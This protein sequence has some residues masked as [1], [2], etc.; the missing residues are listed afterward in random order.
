MGLFSLLLAYLTYPKG[1]TGQYII[2]IAYFI[3]IFPSAIAVKRILVNR[4]YL[5]L[6]VVVLFTFAFLGSSS[7]DWAP[8]RHTSFKSSAKILVYPRYLE[9]ETIESIIDEN[10]KV[11]SSFDFPVGIRG[12]L[13]EGLIS[14]ISSGSIPP[15]YVD[16]SIYLGVRKDAYEAF[17]DEWNII[18]ASENH[19]LITQK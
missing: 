12:K 5:G 14:S 16:K 10:Q 7:P 6:M 15:D 2:P 11:I 17:W 9:S 3:L 19:I 1:E 4:R 8:L 13:S 18:Y